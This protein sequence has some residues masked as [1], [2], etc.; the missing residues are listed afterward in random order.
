[1]TELILRQLGATS[2]QID[3]ER[4]RITAEFGASKEME[5]FPSGSKESG[6]GD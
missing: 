5:S 1:M 4:E 3:R 6:A 2:E